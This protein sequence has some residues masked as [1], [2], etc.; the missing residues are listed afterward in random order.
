[1]ETKLFRVEISTPCTQVRTYFIEASSEK[2]AEEQALYAERDPDEYELDID[3]DN[4]E[5]DISIV[6]K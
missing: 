4:E 6:N 3:E 5:V 2:E 1:M